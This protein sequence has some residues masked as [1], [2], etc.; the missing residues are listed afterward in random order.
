METPHATTPPQQPVHPSPQPRTFMYSRY[1]PGLTSFHFPSTACFRTSMI[2]CT[3]RIMHAGA[4]HH[5]I[6]TG[7]PSCV[8]VLVLG[9]A[10]GRLGRT[11]TPQAHVHWQCTPPTQGRSAAVCCGCLRRCVSWARQTSS[12]GSRAPTGCMRAG[13]ACSGPAHAWPAA[14]H[15]TLTPSPLPCRAW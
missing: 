9:W 12:L 13:G 3:S 10:L 6:P 14:P 2:T 7:L 15:P 1:S 8:R 11:S 5:P 4:H